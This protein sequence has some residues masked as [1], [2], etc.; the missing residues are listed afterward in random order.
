[1]HRFDR[2]LRP[3]VVAAVAL[4]LS[5]CGGGSTGASSAPS[6]SSTA[7][8]PAG[9]VRISSTTI[10]GLGSVLVDAQGRTLYI[11]EPDAH[12]KVTCVADCAKIWPPAFLSA[13]QKASA[14]GD[15]KQSMLGSA[16]DPDGGDVITYGGWPLYTYVGDSSAGQHNGQALNLNG[17]LWYVIS[18]SGT[19]VKTKP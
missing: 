12:A 2:G 1:M 19:V 6:A 4:A 7:S 3:L 11:F 5:A 9:G 13:G 8:A 10:A 17:G 14:T 15:V 18:P 16:A